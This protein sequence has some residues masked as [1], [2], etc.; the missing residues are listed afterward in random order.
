[1]LFC[2]HEIN[3][4]EG[5][6]ME[7]KELAAACLITKRDYFHVI[8]SYNKPDGKRKNLSFSTGLRVRGNKRKAETILNMIRNSFDIPL[9]D[10]SL[11]MERKKIKLLIKKHLYGNETIEEVKPLK[12]TEKTKHVS[13]QKYP[14]TNGL[15]KNM[16]FS[17]YL[18]YWL[19]NVEKYMIEEN[20]YATYY[21]NIVNRIIPY[22]ENTLVTL[23][24]LT[25]IDIQNYYSKCLEGFRIGKQEF[26][27]VKPAT[28]KRRHSNIR[29]A[30]Q[31]A[32]EIELIQKN[33]ADF[34]ALPKI[35]KFEG[36][37]YKKDELEQLFNIVK[38]TKIE[39]AVLVA[40]FYGLRRSEVVGLK[41]DA[42][43]FE[44]KTISIKHTV[45]EYVLKGEMKRK[46]K[47]RA[48]NQSSIRT[49]PLVEPFEKLL[50][51]LLEQRSINMKLF[52]NSYSRK[53]IDYI[54]VDEMGER[55]KPGYVTQTYNKILKRNNLKIIRFHDL[56]HSCATLL[57]NNGVDL[58]DIQHWLGHSTITTTAN[59]YTHFDYSRK[60]DSAN[61]MMNTLQVIS[62]N[63]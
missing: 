50:A 57:Y 17:S 59:I 52:G 26:K 4:V 23:G 12:G 33:P 30:L 44:N 48:K 56:R 14:V 49:L 62:K 39:F 19:E 20:T 10:E 58:K 40:A 29:K 28:V 25:S 60:I 16:L 55:I 2:N 5:G 51:K 54:Y 35:V 41:W 36:K 8:L 21:L 32:Y 1:M 42:I 27:S 31:Y 13:E 6:N 61:I 34:V 3:G 47:D 43:D 37:T 38:D 9:S 24:E 15:H 22:F 11:E 63:I 7:D 53:Y 18:Y 45:T 46:E